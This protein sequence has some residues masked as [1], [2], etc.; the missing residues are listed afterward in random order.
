ML[1]KFLIYMLM[2]AG[3]QAISAREIMMQEL[4]PLEQ[5]YGHQTKSESLLTM[6]EL[7]IEYGYMLYE[8]MVNIEKEGLVLE[9]E[10]IRDYGVVY[11]NDTYQGVLDRDHKKLP[12]SLP[13]GK[14]TLKIFVENIGRIT[15]G[16]EIL[17]NFKGLFGEVYLDDEEVEDW[18]MTE[19]PVR[20]TK[21]NDLKFQSKRNYNLPSFYKASFE[22][23]D[24]AD[25]YVD[26]T[27]WGMGEV[28]IN[29]QHIGTFW[30][31]E[32]QQSLHASSSILKQGINE[33]V[34]F[35]LKNNQ[36]KIVRISDSPV[37]K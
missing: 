31:E 36:Q 20:K 12:L 17:D 16:P 8:T 23:Q 19:L 27:G 10:N 14:C 34:V 3:V 6:N 9:V 37:F 22:I 33:L 26:I 11:L 1:R 35:E 30:E 29:G 15:Y 28:W 24:I 25:F 13:V 21:V 7:D 5:I 32:R 4:A 18:K 2:M